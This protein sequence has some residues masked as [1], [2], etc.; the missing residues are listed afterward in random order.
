M[1]NRLQEHRKKGVI[2]DLAKHPGEVE[3]R[4]DRFASH[5]RDIGNSRV[6]IKPEKETK[7]GEE[8]LSETVAETHIE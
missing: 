7:G 6:E 3:L 8:Q 5:F 4:K 2:I 1:R